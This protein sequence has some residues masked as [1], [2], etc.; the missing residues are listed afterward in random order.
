MILSTRFIFTQNGTSSSAQ[1]IC[2]KKK[3]IKIKIKNT[4]LRDMLTCFVPFLCNV[5]SFI[6][7]E[8][9][10]LYERTFF[11][12]VGDFALKRK[13]KKFVLLRFE[14]YALS[15]ILRID[16]FWLS[17]RWLGVT[18]DC[19]HSWQCFALY[20]V[21][22]FILIAWR[23]RRRLHRR[24]WSFAISIFAHWICQWQLITLEID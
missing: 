4:L 9:M 1:I 21:M 15:F 5:W 11:F 22:N 23:R 24:E 12:V 6:V 16:S 18:A 2:R 7:D 19:K 17:V 3:K 14:L 10:W 8:L 13:E 20:D